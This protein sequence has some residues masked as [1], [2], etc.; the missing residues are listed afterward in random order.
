MSLDIPPV[1]LAEASAEPPASMVLHPPSINADAA[2]AISR[3]RIPSL[4]LH[5]EENRIREL[6][7]RVPGAA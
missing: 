3:L 4:L 7:F 6:W 1:A 2:A 5:I